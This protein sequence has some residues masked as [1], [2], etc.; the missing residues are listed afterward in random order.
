MSLKHVIVMVSK[1]YSPSVIMVNGSEKLFEREQLSMC[2]DNELGR[3]RKVNLKIN[4]C[5]CVEI[6]S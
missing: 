2:R 4:N 5:Q 6:M 3:Y 1:S